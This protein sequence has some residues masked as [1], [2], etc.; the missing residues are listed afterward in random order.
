M[1]KFLAETASLVVQAILEAVVGHLWSLASPILKE[2]PGILIAMP[3]LAEDRGAV[4]GSLAAKYSTM[5]YL[6]EAS[7]AKELLKSKVTYSAIVVGVIGGLYVILLVST[8]AEPL[9]PLIYFLV[10]RGLILLTL[11]PLTAYLCYAAFLKGLDIDLTVVSLITVIADLLSA[12]SLFI[13]FS[14]VSLVFIAVT[15]AITYKSLATAGLRRALGYKKEYLASSLIAST[16]STLAGLTLAEG[17][18]TE[19]P[20]LLAVAPLIMALN[21]SASMNFA[22]WLGTALALGEVEASRPFSKK[23]LATNLRVT[24]EVLVALVSSSALFALGPHG[25]RALE[26]ALVS[27]LLLRA[28]M[29][30]I[31]IVLASWSYLRGWDPDLITI[32]I[33]SSL[34]D[35]L[36]T[37]VV[38]LTYRLLFNP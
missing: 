7:N 21:G 8:V 22:S 25:I 19:V 31:T 17:G 18:A 13:V 33:L 14:E 34:G 29:P 20:L 38:L 30:L 1:R 9:A 26:V 32:P 35:L 3:G 36:S 12:I 6:G 27:T 28:V 23:V 37:N 2:H 4:Y 16:I 24:A 5:L 15:I 10:S 11:V